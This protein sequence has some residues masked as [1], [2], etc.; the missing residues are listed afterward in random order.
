MKEKKYEYVK[1]RVDCGELCWEYKLIGSYI[2]GRMAHDEDVSDWSEN[3]IVDVTCLM[4]DVDKDQRK[5]VE[6]QW[7]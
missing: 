3:Q 4:L 6:V 1:A 2:V 7:L 5:I